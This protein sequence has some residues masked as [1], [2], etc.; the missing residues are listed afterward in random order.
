MLFVPVSGRFGMGEFARSSALARAVQLRWPAAGVH[1]VLEP[2]GALRRRGSV[3]RHLVACIPD[4]SQRR[5]H[6]ADPYLASAR[7]RLRQC[8]PHRPVAGRARFGRARRIHQ[9]PPP[10]APQGVS[11]AVDAAHRRALDCVSG[12]HRRQPHAHRAAEG[13]VTAPPDG[14]L[15]RCDPRARE[16]FARRGGGGGIAGARRIRAR[17]PGRRHGTSGG[18]GC[19]RAFSGRSS[20]VGPGWHRS[21]IRGARGSGHDAGPI[22]SISCRWARFLRRISHG[23]CGMRG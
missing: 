13:A 14:A 9:R 5:G 18:G 15:P 3:S 23:S 7:R 17:G 1:F 10:P 22:G 19:D 12:I 11:S 2:R 20:G 21:P 8:G 6:R 4:L 16:P